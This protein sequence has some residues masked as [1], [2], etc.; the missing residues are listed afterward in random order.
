MTLSFS[1]AATALM[2]GAANLVPVE[3]DCDGALIEGKS[4]GPCEDKL[5]QFVSAEAGPRV[6]GAKTI[7]VK[8]LP[9]WG[10]NLY[11]QE[12]ALLQRQGKR[13]RVLWSHYIVRATAG[14]PGVPD[15]A[16]VY[17]WSFDPQRQRISLRG[18]RTVGKVA[19]IKTGK[20]RGRRTPLATEA[21]CYVKASGRFQPCS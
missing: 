11:S 6:G 21:Y 16:T 10:T 8:Y 13:Y 5:G 9:E 1:F 15:E 19:E 20:A 17:D 14:L 7:A 18:S 4:S 3:F 2:M 12:V